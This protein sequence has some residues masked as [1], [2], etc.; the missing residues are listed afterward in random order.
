MR[1]CSAL[2]LVL[3]SSL[4][5]AL[6]ASNDASI[7]LVKDG[8]AAA[9]IVTAASPSENARLAAVELQ[10]YLELIS[11]AK[12]AIT[13]DAA[14]ASAHAG[15]LILVGSSK[16]TAEIF[17]LKIPSGK[18][19]ALVEEG[20]VIQARGNRLVLAGN[21]TVPYFGTRYAVVEF[22]HRLGVRWFLPTPKGEVVPKMSTVTVEPTDLV[23]RP[24]FPIRNWWDHTRGEAAA[25]CA[26]WKIHNKMNPRS[27]E[28]FGVPGDGS[29]A[30]YLPKDQFDKHPEWFALQRD[31]KRHKNTPCMSCEEMIKYVAERVKKDVRAGR[32][33]T[34]FSPDDGYPRCWCPNCARMSNSFDGMDGNDR[35]PAA[36]YST[37]NEWFYFVQRVLDEVNREYPDYMIATNGYSNRELPPELPPDLR[38]NA[39][40]NLVIMFANIGACSIHAYDDP[41]CWQMQRQAKMVQQWCKLSDKV[42]MYN[43]NYTMLVNKSTITPMVHRLRRNI[44]LLKKWGVIGFHDQDTSNWA[45]SGIPTRLVRARLEWDTKADV[46]AILQDFYSKWFGAAATPMK[47]YYEALETAFDTAPQHG[48]EEVI[49]PAIYTDALMAT[50]DQAM[51]AAESAAKSETEQAH[52]RIERGIY[53]HL[54]A[55]VA[56]LKAKQG[57]DYKAAA[58]AA[59]R[60]T[61]LQEQLTTLAP[62]M[63]SHGRGLWG[64]EWEKKRMDKL[65]A[66]TD[67]PVGKL[68]AALPE[69]AAFRTDPYDDGRF[70]RW[71]NATTDLSGWKSVSTGMGWDAQ[72]FQ[73]EQ[74]H[75]YKGVAWYCFDVDVPDVA[76]G[77]S[78]FLQGPAV[79]NEAWVWVNGRYA[80]HR[81]YIM[82]WSRPQALELEVTPLLVPGQKN[83][84]TVRVLCNFE[85]WGANGIYERM[86]LYAKEPQ[87][88]GPAPK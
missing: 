18:T 55:F 30:S 2:A 43:Y 29:L 48:H 21:D 41:D 11:G 16:L 9:T 88:S 72:G 64:A 67:G 56:M 71:Q 26:E 39:S 40:K 53:D 24:D 28:A 47:T 27:Q 7:V 50:L 4:P 6:A 38:F 10:K 84:I 13:T 5:V 25:E 83:R 76:A 34:A 49:L 75:P 61:E 66:M 54:C 36:G 12:L 46:D 80:G 23:Q 57:C 33:V 44:P 32:R 78:V 68:V 19:K 37:S 69:R 17:D 22:L 1:Q 74:G 42:W 51:L 15:V 79:I 86:F 62:F 35:D 14:D 8:Q 70:E 81:R 85:V 87:A 58:A 82:A 59:V 60:M 52:V 20:F 3:C 45:M 31:G 65:T 63:G 77:K 73:N